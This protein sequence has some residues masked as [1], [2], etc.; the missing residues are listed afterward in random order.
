MY[1]RFSNPGPR[2][3]LDPAALL[4]PVPTM[5]LIRFR[6]SYPIID[7]LHNLSLVEYPDLHTV[8]SIPARIVTVVTTLQLET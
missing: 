5:I 1:K 2:K 6:R 8:L 3:G 7:Y 4:T